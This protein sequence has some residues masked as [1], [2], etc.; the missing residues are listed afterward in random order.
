MRQNSLLYEEQS[1]YHLSTLALGIVPGGRS[2]YGPM[3]C[4]LDRLQVQVRYINNLARLQLF[5]PPNIGVFFLHR[6]APRRLLSRGTYVWPRWVWSDSGK[7]AQGLLA[8]DQTES[9]LASDC[10]LLACQGSYLQKKGPVHIKGR[11]PASNP[12]VIRLPANLAPGN[13]CPLHWTDSSI[14]SRPY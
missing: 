7:V 3:R 10:P 5:L 8:S 2:V 1:I 4:I 11:L 9:A 13:I 12:A 6:F 14:S